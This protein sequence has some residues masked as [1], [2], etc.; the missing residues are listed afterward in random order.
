M[1][2]F[3]TPSAASS[4]AFAWITSLWGAVCDLAIASHV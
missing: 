3:A 4:N 1:W 2:V